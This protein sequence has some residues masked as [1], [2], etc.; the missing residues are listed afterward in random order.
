MTINLKQKGVNKMKRTVLMTIF[1]FTLFIIAAGISMVLGTNPQIPPN[2]QDWQTVSEEA[3]GDKAFKR[4]YLNDSIPP[5]HMVAE[6]R[7]KDKA[8]GTELL[9]WTEFLRPDK[10]NP[11][12]V[13]MLN[14]F[15]F[16][17]E[18][19]KWQGPIDTS[20]FDIGT[21]PAGEKIPL[22]RHDSRFGKL[23]KEFQVRAGVKEDEM[24]TPFITN[25]QTLLRVCPDAWIDNQMPLVIGPETEKTPRQ[26]FILDGKRRELA[27][28]DLE[29]VKEHCQIQPQIVH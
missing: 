26:Y 4:V 25:K 12:A 11:D 18:K 7:F 3:V 5:R 13:R 9:I 23:F 16:R 8:E 24:E 19:A 21:L 14:R 22:F 10:A 29:W 27:E 15:Y 20:V 2:Y 17:K 28:F 1:A 6:F